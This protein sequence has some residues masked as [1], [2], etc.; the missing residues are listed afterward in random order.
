MSKSN[1]STK[2][3]DIYS[4]ELCSI[5]QS[6]NGDFLN[7]TSLPTELSIYEAV[8]FKGSKPFVYDHLY[9]DAITKDITDQSF[10]Y[11]IEKNARYHAIKEYF[12][13][14]KAREPYIFKGQETFISQISTSQNRRYAAAQKIDDESKITNEATN[15]FFI[16]EIAK[17]LPDQTILDKE[18]FKGLGLKTC[19]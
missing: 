7:N 4:K 2:I 15:N 12:N 3:F 9:S 10:Q 16:K 14:D 1:T 6:E 18:A 5:L 19:K 8:D 13:L 17:L 11:F